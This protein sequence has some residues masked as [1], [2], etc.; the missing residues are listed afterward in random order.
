MSLKVL[1][2]LLIDIYIYLSLNFKKILQTLF[3]IVWPQRHFK[4]FSQPVSS[5]G[6]Q[7]Y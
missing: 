2:R 3:E 1:P 5:K 4:V 6:F 7:L